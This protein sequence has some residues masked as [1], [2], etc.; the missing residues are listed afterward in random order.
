M[1]GASAGFPSAAVPLSSSYAPQSHIELWRR[2][3]RAPPHSGSLRVREDVGA[4]AARGR[5]G[6]GGGWSP[7]HATL[8]G[9]AG[10]LTFA[11]EAGGPPLDTVAIA[12]VRAV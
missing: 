12:A 7:R 4:S 5:G 9:S 1:R 6:A 3:E 11:A 8:D 10:V 2:L